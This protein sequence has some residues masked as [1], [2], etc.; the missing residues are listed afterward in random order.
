MQRIKMF[1][2]FIQRYRERLPSVILND[3]PRTRSRKEEHY[4]VHFMKLWLSAKCQL[5]V[6]CRNNNYL[7]GVFVCQLSAKEICRNVLQLLT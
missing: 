3:D 4:S 6:L 7:N 1:Q 5:L 2:K